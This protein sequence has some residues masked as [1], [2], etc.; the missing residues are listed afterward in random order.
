MVI[1]HVVDAGP[2]STL[3]YAPGLRR[4]P[5]FTGLLLLFFS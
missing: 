5:E 3:K 1:V 4:L 2:K